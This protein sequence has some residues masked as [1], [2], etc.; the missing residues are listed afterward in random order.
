MKTEY[1]KEWHSDLVTRFDEI[2]KLRTLMFSD[3]VSE[4]AKSVLSKN[5]T[6]F[7]VSNFEGSI[8]SLAQSYVEDLNHSDLSKIHMHI[9][10]HQA[11]H[12]STD[13]KRAAALA[14]LFNENRFLINKDMYPGLEFDYNP[15]E[16]NL[17]KI[18]TNLGIRDI[19]EHLNSDRFTCLF[20]QDLQEQGLLTRDIDNALSGFMGDY[21]DNYRLFD[22]GAKLDHP[23][24]VWNTFLEDIIRKRN[25][26]V[27]GT[28]QERGVPLGEVEICTLKIFIFLKACCLII[29]NE[30]KNGT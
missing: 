9:R 19:F 14:K 30:H 12:F 17:R 4:D 16:S 20:T 6:V 27:H 28:G 13:Q 1:L 24:G 5:Y 7:L 18:F 10:C 21:I 3:E 23:T 29:L 8:K 11:S 25:L 2:G 22:F 26:I 15:K